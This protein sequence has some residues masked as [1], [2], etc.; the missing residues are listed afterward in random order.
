M[1]ENYIPRQTVIITKSKKKGGIF[2]QKNDSTN[3]NIPIIVLRQS[4]VKAHGSSRT[5]HWLSEGRVYRDADPS[6]YG[7]G[8]RGGLTLSLTGISEAA[9]PFVM[10]QRAHVQS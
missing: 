7:T 4:S 10:S 6:D 9:A 2:R 8:R 1:A 3:K 5:P